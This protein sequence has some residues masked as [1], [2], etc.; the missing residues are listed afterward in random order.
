MDKAERAS[1]V[2]EHRRWLNN[3]GYEAIVKYLLNDAGHELLT[4]R[5][6]IKSSGKQDRKMRNFC[7]SIRVDRL[8]FLLIQKN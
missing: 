4:K 3:G 1:D 7:F 5:T 2:T 8:L 6:M